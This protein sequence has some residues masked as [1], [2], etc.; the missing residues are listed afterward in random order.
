VSPKAAIPLIVLP[1]YHHTVIAESCL[2]VRSWGSLDVNLVLWFET[3][4]YEP[5]VSP[6]EP[7]DEIANK[8]YRREN[9]VPSLDSRGRLEV[10]L[11]WVWQC[12]PR[13]GLVPIDFELQLGTV[14]SYSESARGR[15]RPYWSQ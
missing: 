12:S 1:S 11:D 2:A 5:P 9:V 8:R 7:R 6:R 15:S 10:P 14:R 13:K 4:L 3:F